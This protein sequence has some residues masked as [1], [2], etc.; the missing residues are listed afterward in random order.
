MTPPQNVFSLQIKLTGVQDGQLHFQ[1][2]NDTGTMPAG[3]PITAQFLSDWLGRKVSVLV[4]DGVA[5]QVRRRKGLVTTAKYP[6][7]V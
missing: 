4:V 1:D 7:D 6:R 5:I 3:F 2:K